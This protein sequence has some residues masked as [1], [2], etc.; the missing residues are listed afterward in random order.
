MSTTMRLYT[1][2]QY[3]LH[4]P[5]IDLTPYDIY[6]TFR[7]NDKV[8]TLTTDDV[9]VSY[10]NEEDETQILVVLS[11]SQTAF[12]MKRSIFVQVN[13]VNGEMRYATEVSEMPPKINL[14]E[15]IV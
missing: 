3:T 7:Q 6:V 8:V 5:G 1:T 10:D 12:E 4:V 2:P 11:Q 13:W 14:L 15:E 9:S